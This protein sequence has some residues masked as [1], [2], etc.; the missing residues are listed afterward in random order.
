MHLNLNIKKLIVHSYGLSFSN[1]KPLM[2]VALAYAFVG[3]GLALAFNVAY[4]QGYHWLVPDIN[5][6]IGVAVL[7]AIKVILFTLFIVSW[8]KIVSKKIFNR[9]MLFYLKVLTFVSIW[10]VWHYVSFLGIYY[11][12]KGEFSLPH[13]FI[14]ALGAYL[15]FVW[16]RFYSMLARLLDKEDIESLSCFFQLTQGQTIRICMALICVVGPCSLSIYWFTLLYTGNLW[17]GEF[18]INFILLFFT[19]IWINHCYVQKTFLKE[20]AQKR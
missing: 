2:V 18:C 17:L 15:P 11:I 9:D 1:F 13:L 3:T 8:S 12:I 7:A 20:L 16:V 4:R 14:I 6:Q 5:L 10:L 19:S